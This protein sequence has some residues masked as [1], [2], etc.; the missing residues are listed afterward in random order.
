MKSLTSLLF[1]F[2]FAIT[3]ACDDEQP[4]PEEDDTNQ[5]TE[6]VVEKSID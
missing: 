5:R 2:L 4:A 3:V 1:V 6:L